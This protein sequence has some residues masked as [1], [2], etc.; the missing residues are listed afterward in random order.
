MKKSHVFAIAIMILFT[1]KPVLAIV[2]I[3]NMNIQ[4]DS[5]KTGFD[6]QVNIDFSGK[7]GNTQSRNAG[8]GSR[9]QWFN[10]TDTSFI[11]LNYEYGEVSD[12]KDTDKSFVHIRHI[13]YLSNHWAW[14][15]FTQMETNEFTR[16]SLRSLLG[17][18]GRYQIPLVSKQQLSYLGIGLFRSKETLDEVIATTD[19]GT[20]Y[21]TRANL[22]LVYKYKLSDTTH[23]SNTIYYQPNINNTDDYRLLEQFR[24]NVAIT[25]KLS[26][27]LSFDVNHDNL[28][29]QNIKTTDSSYTT[30]LT[31]QF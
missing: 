13:R 23:L 7:N 2:N 10:T 21:Q 16:L 3:E 9:L 15:V 22:Y 20:D 5:E 29:P 6:A 27:Q 30:G 8:L 4:P 25:S 24:F 28:P 17:T 26:L 18:G 12:I 1:V 31:Y 14:E 19:A 11:A